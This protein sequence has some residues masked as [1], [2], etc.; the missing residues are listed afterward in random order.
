MPRLDIE[1][2]GLLEDVDPAHPHPG[3]RIFLL[4]KDDSAEVYA[5]A[6]G[7]GM[8]SC[9]CDAA[10]ARLPVCKHRDSVRAMCEDGVL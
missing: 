10:R 5:V 9:T 6:C 8:A 1:H 2:Y 4:K 7:D 3:V